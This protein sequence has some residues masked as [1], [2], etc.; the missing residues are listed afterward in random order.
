MDS[1]W[2]SIGLTAVTL[3]ALLAGCASDKPHEYGQDRPP[4]DQVDPRDRGL[5]SMDVIAASDKMAMEL[6]SSPALN[7]S[8][9]QWT[10]VIDR[11]EDSTSDR[12]FSGRNYDIFL[13]RLRTRLFQLGHGRIQLIENKARFHDLQNKELEGP[14]RDEFGQGSGDHAVAAGVQPDYVLYGKAMD[15]PNRATNYY[16]LQFDMTSFRTREMVWTGMYEVRTAR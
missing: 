7:A 12:N 14:P 3:A 15:L 6:L 5:Q 9:N 10:V 4:A 1:G 2:K 16:Q 11:V 8:R 13:E